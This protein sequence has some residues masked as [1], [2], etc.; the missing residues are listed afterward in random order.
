MLAAYVNLKKAFNS[1]HREALWDLLRLRGILAGIIGILSG[2]YSGT[3]T[4]VK[5]GGSVSNLFSVH[6]RVSQRCVLAP[7]LFNICMDWVLSRVLDQ[8]YCEASVGNTKITDLLFADDAVMFAESL[9]VLVMVLE[10]LQQAKPL[11]LQVSWPKTKVQVFGGFLDEK[12]SLFM[13][14][15]ST[16]ISWKFSHN[17][18]A[19]SITMVSHVKYTHAHLYHYLHVSISSSICQPGSQYLTITIETGGLEPHSQGGLSGIQDI[20]LLCHPASFP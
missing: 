19:W 17:L 15:A 4:S 18:V 2:L 1:V 20:T 6:T 16:L 3:E 9:E 8:S 5:C 10:A 7:S 13:R 12:Y 14:V 11:G